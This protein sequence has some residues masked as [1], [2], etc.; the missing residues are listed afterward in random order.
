M[1]F[2]GI[3]HTHTHQHHSITGII[4]HSDHAAAAPLANRLS[5]TNRSLSAVHAFSM[6]ILF[7]AISS[8]TAALLLSITT[9]VAVATVYS[10]IPCQRCCSADHPVVPR[11]L[12]HLQQH[13]V[14][15]IFIQQHPAPQVIGSAMRGT[16]SLPISLHAAVANRAGINLLRSLRGHRGQVG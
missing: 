4:Q 7:A 16:D 6:S 5:E 13:L 8:S 3:G 2:R 10:S 15:R 12:P 14:S 1:Y 9:A 11:S